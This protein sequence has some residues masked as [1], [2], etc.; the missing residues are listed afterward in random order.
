MQQVA[1]EVFQL[2]HLS[3][4]TL[5]GFNESSLFSYQLML[6]QGMLLCLQKKWQVCSSLVNSVD[7]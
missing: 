5:D 4:Q 3:V 7:E 1:F 2:G 6:F